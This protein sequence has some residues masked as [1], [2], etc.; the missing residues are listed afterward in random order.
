MY[1][2]RIKNEKINISQEDQ[3]LITDTPNYSQTTPNKWLEV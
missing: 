2:I 1:I 3:Y